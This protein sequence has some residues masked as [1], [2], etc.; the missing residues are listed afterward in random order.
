[1]DED[2]ARRAVGLL[3]GG[4]VGSKLRSVVR[5]LSGRDKNDDGARHEE[6]WVHGANGWSMAIGM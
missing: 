1:M 2:V 6:S 3:D 4:G 5:L